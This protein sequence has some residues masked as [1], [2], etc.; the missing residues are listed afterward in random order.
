MSNLK[1][2][3][4]TLNPIDPSIAFEIYARELQA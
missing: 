4:I 2:I 1:L 3:Q